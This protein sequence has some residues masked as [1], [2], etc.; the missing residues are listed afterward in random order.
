[1]PIV[2]LADG[3]ILAQSNAIMLYLAEGSDLI[4]S[5]AYDRA[6]MFQWLFWEQYSHETA[7]LC[8]AFTKPI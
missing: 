7:L 8:A 3:R 5:D 2:K 1:M 6:L 4:P